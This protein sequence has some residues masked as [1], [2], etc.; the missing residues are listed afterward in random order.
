MKNPDQL[1]CDIR[2]RLDNT[3]HTHL[4]LVTDPS[5]ASW[6]HNFPLGS[7]SRADLEKNFDHYRVASL[8]WQQWAAAR[9]VTLLNASRLVFGT[10]QRV[11]THVA[12]PDIDTAARIAG[13]DWTDRLD[14]GRRRIAALSAAS[15][16]GNLIRAVRDVDTYSDA[17]FDLLCTTAAWF[18]RHADTAHGL[19]PRQVPI[20]GLHAK[21]LNTRHGLIAALAGLDQLDL[22][23]RHPP[24]IHFTYLDPHHRAGGGRWHDSATVGDFMT[25]A[26]HPAVIVISENKD[27][28]IHFPPLAGGIA[29]EGAGF[30]GGT[31]AA[32]DWVRTCTTLLYWGDLDAAG[33][34]ILNGYREAGLA[35]TSILMDLKTFDRFQQF[36]TATDA[37][38]NP[39]TCPPRRDLLYLT[40]PEHA[41]YARLT[42]PSWGGYRRIEQERIPLEVASSAVIETLAPPT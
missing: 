25:S 35:V 38:G 26:Y 10:A 6:P 14:R 2:R 36:G 16:N 18:R 23:P 28:A 1:L 39:L 19:T 21:W 20:A 37:R 3:W 41:L 42:D 27:T 30:G 9:A 15:F 17:D 11:P 22:L 4:E 40:G 24:R 7:V 13:P 29:I 8:T 31:A 33:L 12:V 34:E 32:V 5:S